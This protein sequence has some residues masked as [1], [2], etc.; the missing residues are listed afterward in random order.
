MLCLH[1]EKRK[2][3]YGGLDEMI[4]VLHVSDAF[5]Q[6]KIERRRIGIDVQRLAALHANIGRRR[7]TGWII[8][9]HRHRDIFATAI[10]FYLPSRHVNSGRSIGRIVQRYLPIR[11][12]ASR[13]K[14]AERYLV[15]KRR[16][17]RH[18][19]SRRDVARID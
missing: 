11:I 2:E 15:E 18:G 3:N 5:V 14:R 6:P 16:K 9:I 10:R 17:L 7:K 8:K 12:T 19:I 13:G 4:G 1:V